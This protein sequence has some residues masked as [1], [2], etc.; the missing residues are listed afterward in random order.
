M[1]GGSSTPQGYTRPSA[2]AYIYVSRDASNYSTVT[3]QASVTI[4][5]PAALGPHLRDCTK[6]HFFIFI[7][8]V[9]MSSYT[10]N[11]DLWLERSRLAGMVLAAVSYG[12]C[13]NP[14]AI[15]PT[16]QIPNA[17]TRHLLSLDPS[18]NCCSDSET[19]PRWSGCSSPVDAPWLRLDHLCPCN[20][21]VCGKCPVYGDD[22][23]R[24]AGC[25]RWA[26]C[27][28]PR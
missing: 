28:D 6:P 20:D 5:R 26:S 23:D 7:R 4:T 9:D 8:F 16:M 3:T 24:P 25:T 21:W 27:V 12:E 2:S 14:S 22:M 18:G 10:P 11:T 19:A 13:P 1:I 17:T 15:R